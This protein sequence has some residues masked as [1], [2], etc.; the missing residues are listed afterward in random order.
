MSTPVHRGFNANKWTALAACSASIAVVCGAVGSHA[1][2]PHLA[3]ES[4]RAWQVGTNYQLAHGLALLLVAQLL[5][6]SADDYQRY[7]RVAQLFTLG[8]ILFSGSL[9]GLAL[10]KWSVLGPITPIGG[11]CFIAG[12]LLLMVRAWTAPPVEHTT[13]VEQT[14]SEEI[15]E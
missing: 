1:L 9:Y 15:S 10:T 6:K 7:L 5:A 2:R 12:W 8:T 11:L 14:Q 13:L 3:V 4:M